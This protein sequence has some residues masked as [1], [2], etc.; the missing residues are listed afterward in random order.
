M[1]QRRGKTLNTHNYLI[2]NCDKGL[3]G[4]KQAYNRKHDLIF[5]GNGFFRPEIFKWSDMELQ[6]SMEAISRVI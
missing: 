3:E 1:L 5:P 2:T 4:E 6:G